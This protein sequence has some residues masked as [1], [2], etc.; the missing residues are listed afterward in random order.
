[1]LNKNYMF[2]VLFLLMQ[3]IFALNGDSN[4]PIQIDANH[5]TV[6]EKQ[7]QSIFEGNVV[8]TRGSFVAHAIKGT[9]NQDK[10]GD[11]II[12][13][14]GSPAV[15]E[16]LASDG[17]KIIGQ[18]DHF[19]YNTK[20]SLAILNGRARVRKGK[21]LVIGD[22]L[23]Y[24]TKTEVYSAVSDMGNGVTK[25]TSGRVTVILDQNDVSPSTKQSSSSPKK[26]N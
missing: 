9:A 10:N 25:K 11:R 7:M 24:N 17:N 15:F 6:D 5:A 4:K 18:C 14:Y 13:L 22:K 19:T 12:D 23:T 1:M 8:I 2:L 26:I 20:T 16:Q 3:S 21:S